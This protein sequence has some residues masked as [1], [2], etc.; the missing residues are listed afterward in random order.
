MNENIIITA[1]ILQEEDRIEHSLRPDSL[2]FFFGQEK[3][4]NNLHVFIKAAGKRN[5]PLDHILL[6]TVS[7]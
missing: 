3:I 7:G 4:K 6:S 2:D 1:P 5:E